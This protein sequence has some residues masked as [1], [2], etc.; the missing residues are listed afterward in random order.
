MTRA[1]VAMQ[2]L[3]PG[4]GLPRALDPRGLDPGLLTPGF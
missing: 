1:G 3:T 2:D 4:L